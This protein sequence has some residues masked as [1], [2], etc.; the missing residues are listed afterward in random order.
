VVESRCSLRL[1]RRIAA[2]PEEVWRALTEPESLR[3]WLA[4]RAEGGL[5]SAAELDLAL[6]S[7]EPIVARVREVEHARVLELDWDVG[8]DPS[9]V[10]FELRPDGRGGTVL[11]LDHARIDE[12]VGM[13]YL[14]E[15]ARA[16]ERLQRRLE[17]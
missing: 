1:T 11:V 8:G 13:R 2:P 10:R 5:E 16:I 6:G 3:R 12:R 7:G 4:P 9:T 17:S 15:W 14:D